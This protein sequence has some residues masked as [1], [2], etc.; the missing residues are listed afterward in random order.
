MRCLRKQKDGFRVPKEWRF[1]VAETNS[2]TALEATALEQQSCII[3]ALFFSKA[4]L[5][6]TY[7]NGT[8]SQYGTK[9]SSIFWVLFWF[10]GIYGHPWLENLFISSFLVLILFSKVLM[11]KNVSI[12]FSI[13]KLFQVR[14]GIVLIVL[15]FFAS[16]WH[17]LLLARLFLF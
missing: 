9:Q 3:F 11:Y 16:N 1:S 14:H 7:S 2:N 17:I 6:S 10:W 8:F 12:K 15:I 5:K 13:R 4:P